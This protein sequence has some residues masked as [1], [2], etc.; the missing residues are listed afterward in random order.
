VKDALHPIT[1]GRHP[2][3]VSGVLLRIAAGLA[4]GGVAGFYVLRGTDL[5]AVWNL[6]RH[7]I[8]GW[9]G[10]SLA[11]VA[12]TQLVK[13]L[14]WQVIVGGGHS[15]SFGQAIRGL[16]VGQA[17][18]LLMPF[19]VGDF[20]RAYLV[21][22]HLVAGSVFTFYTVVVEKALDAVMLLVSLVVLLS[23]APWPDWLSRSGLWMGLL[24][25]AMVALGLTAAW[26]WRRR[27]GA[28][29]P[30]CGNRAC[31]EL[32]EGGLPQTFV[33]SSLLSR[34]G[35]RLL[36]PAAQLAD[37]LAAARHDGRLLWMVLWSVAVWGLG[38]ATNWAVLAALGLAVNWS[39]AVL[40][41]AA[42]YAGVAVPAPP[43]R[44]G[45]W[46]LLVVLALSVY[47][48]D[49]SQAMACGVLLHLV[50]VV[51]LLVAGGVAALIR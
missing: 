21:G 8:P 5:P 7:A 31:P 37:G 40:I 12:V 23:W 42:I 41:L 38:A 32:A 35:D 39:A 10:L 29:P 16:L 26:F 11:L 51:P 47:G 15:L 1:E 34:L 3:R 44:V 2:V 25:L 24:T 28:W 27:R 4:L 36:T 50:V 19:R 48:V 33:R 22:R 20:A 13:A 49:Q 46:H 45:V 18:N 30:P 14:R 9:I 43:T 6:L 17:L